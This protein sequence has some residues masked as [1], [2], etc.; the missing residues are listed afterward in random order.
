MPSRPSS[1]TGSA[2]STAEV[3]LVSTAISRRGD[4]RFSEHEPAWPDLAE[5]AIA[6]IMTALPGLFC[7]I[8]RRPPALRSG[9]G[10]MNI[11]RGGE[12]C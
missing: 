6:E 10:S 4:D 8:E 7:V 5:Q 3:A 11:E 9:R 12:P 1:A 2:S